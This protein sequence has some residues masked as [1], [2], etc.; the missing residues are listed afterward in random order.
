MQISVFP[1][2][3]LSL[4]AFRELGADC[5]KFAL[6]YP[7]LR[8]GFAHRAEYLEFYRQ[9]VAAARQRGIKVMPHVSIL[10]ADTPF[11]PMKGIYRG[12]TLERFKAEYRDMV[13]LIARELKPDY[14]D[15]LTEPDTHAKLTGLRELNQPK[16]IADVVQN[17]L[18]GWDDAGMRCG[19]GSGSWSSTE[20][21]RAFVQIRE[22]DYLA[23]HVY[24]FWEPLDR[25]FMT[26]V[27]MR[28]SWSRRLSTLSCVRNGP[29][30]IRHSL[31]S[32]ALRRTTAA[33]HPR[34]NRSRRNCN[35]L[36]DGFPGG[37]RRSSP[38][39][40]AVQAAA[41]RTA[42]AATE[43]RGF[44]R[45]S[46]VLEPALRT[47]QAVSARVEAPR[48]GRNRRKRRHSQPRQARRTGT[49]PITRGRA[50]SPASPAP[51]GRT[52]SGACLP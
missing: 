39:V 14:L 9:V 11:S 27:M 51:A 23:I 5:V 3:F 38:R 50:G 20:F 7:L 48:Y 32:M 41:I 33:P 16:V 43:D 49:D 46:A 30:R 2:V 12:L 35:L 26:L 40:R 37:R 42:A 31:P 13:M 47:V 25:K 18:R 28:S 4:D 8:P 29:Q 6:Q 44:L 24:S 19:A 36:G 17:A 34:R 22:L 45:G 21:A 10:F 15:L 52:R 1:I